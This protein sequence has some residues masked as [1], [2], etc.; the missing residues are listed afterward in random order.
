LSNDHPTDVAITTLTSNSVTLQ[1]SPTSSTSTAN[2]FQLIC[3]VSNFVH[4][5]CNIKYE[6]RPIVPGEIDGPKVIDTVTQTK[7]SFQY[8]LKDSTGN[9]ISNQSL[10]NPLT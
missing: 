1:Y 8:T 4:A 9:V 7:E 2:D 10:P 3:K 6:V 5:S